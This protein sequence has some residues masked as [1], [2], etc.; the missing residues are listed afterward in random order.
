MV[1]GPV[2]PVEY[3]TYHEV[4]RGL[5]FKCRD[6]G[7]GYYADPETQCQVRADSS[8]HFESMNVLSEARHSV[9]WREPAGCSGAE[10]KA[11]HAGF[12]SKPFVTVADTYA[13]GN[14]VGRCG[15]GACRRASC[16]ASS[17][18]TALCSTRPSGCAIGGSTWT[19]RTAPTSTPSTTTSTRTRT[20]TT[21]KPMKS[22]LSKAVSLFYLFHACRRFHLCQ[23]QIFHVENKN[24]FLLNEL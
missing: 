21:S 23:W 7:P 10:N 22:G 15:T 5:S 11:L 8:V 24:A 12:V 9:A 20:A 1:A 13:L 17:A 3:P 18:P 2:G 6:R 16:T 14:F 19:V 4:P